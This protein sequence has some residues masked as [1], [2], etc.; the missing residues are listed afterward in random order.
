MCIPT[1][2]FQTVYLERRPLD[3]NSFYQLS[4]LY[5]IL[6]ILY[7]I[8]YCVRR[9]CNLCLN[10]YFY[11]NFGQSYTFL[12][13]P[14]CLFLDDSYVLSPETCRNYIYIYIYIYT[15]THIYIYTHTHT[16][17]ISWIVSYQCKQ[18]EITFSCR[19][20]GHAETDHRDIWTVF[21]AGVKVKLEWWYCKNNIHETNTSE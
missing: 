2:S 10:V 17:V 20:R 12:K 18:K 7:M 11:L 15:H 1:P 4:P 13:W 3:A 21:V 6:Y 5:F 14:F 19:H 9:Y 8:V 16:S